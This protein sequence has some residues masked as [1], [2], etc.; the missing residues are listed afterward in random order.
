MTCI[1][2]KEEFKL[3]IN[4]KVVCLTRKAKNEAKQDKK[5]Y[6]YY[7]PIN[8]DQANALGLTPDSFIKAELGVKEIPKR[9]AADSLT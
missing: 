1:F 8:K 3:Q 5:T 6:V 9:D 7:I 2:T 4:R